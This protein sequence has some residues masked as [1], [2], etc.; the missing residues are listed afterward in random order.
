MPSDD[1]PN[2]LSCSQLESAIRLS[3]IDLLDSL[4]E[5]GYAH[6]RTSRWNGRATAE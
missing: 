1:D 6:Y 4:E 3:G 2:G 5:F